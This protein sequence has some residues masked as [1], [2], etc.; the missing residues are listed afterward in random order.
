MNGSSTAKVV[1]KNR[2]P[3]TPWANESA[4]KATTIIVRTKQNASCIHF[5]VE[6]FAMAL[7]SFSV[8][9]VLLTCFHL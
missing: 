2:W 5:V 1:G 9:N 6:H 8:A 3:A 7:I 4:G